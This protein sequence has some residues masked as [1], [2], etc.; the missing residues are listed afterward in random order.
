MP[1]IVFGECL[2]LLLSALD[3]SNNRLSKAI[4]VDSSFVSRWIHGKRVPPYNSSYID[5]I[6]E[7][8]SNNVHNSFQEQ[9]LN[10]I[11]LNTFV[12]KEITAGIK[13]KIKK[14]L[15]EAQGYSIEFNKKRKKEI[16]IN[17]SNKE[18]ISKL[19][20]DDP[21]NHTEQ[22]ITHFTELS[23]EDKVI[24]GAENILAACYDL[25]EIATKQK[26]GKSNIM[27]IT[28]NNF[29]Y[30]E[31]SSH[32]YLINWRD[33]LLKAIKNGWHVLLLIRLNGNTARTIGFM[34]CMI[35]LVQTGQFMP[36]Y[37]KNYDS[38]AIGDELVVVPGI[39][40]LSCFSSNLHSEINCGLFIKNKSAIELY[41]NH[42]QGFIAKHALPLVKI[43][44][45]RNDYSHLLA[46]SEDNI[47]NRFIFKYC[48]SVLTLP[49]HL[50]EKLLD[51]RRLSNDAKIK[52]M[53]FYR[54]RLNAFL[55][56]I[57]NYEYKD[58]YMAA[59]IKDLIKNHQHYLYSFAGIELMHMDT[60]DIIEYLENIIGLLQKYDNYNIA[61]I[62]ESQDNTVNMESFCCMM[63]E[64][65]SVLFESKNPLT[66]MS[67]I[68]VSITE[69][70][71]V[72]AIS[73]YFINL[74]EHIAPAN[75]EKSEVIS[76]LQ[77][78]ITILKQLT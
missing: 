25:L 72:K 35:P 12:D 42:F 45:N 59:S 44:N 41:Q 34:N 22:N 28:Y 43:Y 16:E 69:P 1:N 8:L 76:W 57:Q 2:K 78:Q 65:I 62:P 39:G 71:T 18:H 27:Y 20:N 63:K 77:D 50:Y 70:T 24:L 31:N 36:Y 26:C 47:G 38:I 67:D 64:R 37:I 32:N 75:R 49:E 53:E 5:N 48:F 46:D 4:N 3:I 21:I 60:H 13:E 33:T 9:Q 73:D 56:N 29:M 23:S 61:L 55:S 17:S 40:V 30:A 19:L 52:S 15:L 58:V 51:R 74:W 10:T 14:A 66:G 11:F 54:K 7:Y 68:H 6:S